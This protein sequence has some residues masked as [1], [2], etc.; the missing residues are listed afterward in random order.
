M[1]QE[2]EWCRFSSS[3]AE[4]ATVSVAFLGLF[5][6]TLGE[7]RRY[8]QYHKHFIIY[9]NA[10]LFIPEQ[11]LLNFQLQLVLGGKKNKK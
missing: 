5:M 7:P 1:Y 4:K 8:D 10:E 2:P 6:L 9:Y 3:A 11:M